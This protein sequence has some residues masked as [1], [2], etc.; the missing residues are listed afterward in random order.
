MIVEEHFRRVVDFFHRPDIEYTV[1][2]IQIFSVLSAFVIDTPLQLREVLHPIE[3]VL[4][5]IRPEQQARFCVHEIV[6]QSDRVICADELVVFR[7][8]QVDEK[9]IE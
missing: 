3:T 7:H 8:P 1:C 9:P 5:L 6:D 2:K 4:D